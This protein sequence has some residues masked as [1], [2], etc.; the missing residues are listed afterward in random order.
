[1]NTQKAFK[2]FIRSN[3]HIALAAVSLFGAVVF[4][5]ITS[6]LLVPIL[7]VVGYLGTGSI[8][9]FSRVGAKEIVREQEEIYDDGAMRGID[10]TVT[11]RRRLS[12]LRIDD[13]E[14]AMAIGR[15]SL[16]SDRLIEEERAR[17]K[18]VPQVKGALEEAAG[19][20]TAY[21]GELDAA[22]TS[23]R[24][25]GSDPETAT[26][27]GRATALLT[28]IANRLEEIGASELPDKKALSDF[29]VLEEINDT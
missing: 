18:Y 28:D 25:R 27:S 2:L 10:E 26:A 9:F 17:N 6:G 14:V 11:L 5:L 3:T 19:V 12:V 7:V 20:C 21:L 16:I 22:S 8:L 29:D 23:R 13:P 15:I 1:M 4:G 24:Y